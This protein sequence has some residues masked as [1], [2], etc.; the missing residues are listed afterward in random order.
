MSLDLSF[1]RTSFSVLYFPTMYERTRLV[2]DAESKSTND[3]QSDPAILQS[4]DTSAS[5]GPGEQPEPSE[6]VPS[7]VE[8]TGNSPLEVPQVSTSPPPSL[9]SGPCDPRLWPC[10]S[11]ARIMPV[12]YLILI[13]IRTQPSSNWF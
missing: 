2:G 13:T 11:F 1:P 12:Q 5:S 8:E 6:I 10:V 4:L 7:V 3:M 9:T